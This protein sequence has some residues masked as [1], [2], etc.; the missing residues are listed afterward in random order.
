MTDDYMVYLAS[1]FNHPTEAVRRLRYQEVRSAT[2]HFLDQGLYVYSPIVHNYHID[3]P[4]RDWSFW[5]LYDFAT[6]RRMERLWILALD[7]VESSVGVK[8]ELDLALD[9][10]KIVGVV[11]PKTYEVKEYMPLDTSSLSQYLEDQK[12]WSLQTFGGAPRTRGITEHISKELEEIRSDP[13]DVSEWIDVLILALD[14]YWRAG[15]DTQNLVKRLRYK[16]IINRLRSWPKDVPEDRAVLHSKLCDKP[17]PL[18]YGPC[19]R[20]LGHEGPCALPLDS[21]TL[22][23]LRSEPLPK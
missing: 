2:K 11:N 20:E 15:G 23:D 5:K 10:G 16:Q 18:G 12:E 14:G 8:E 4:H 17:H 3:L 9:L 7:G 13:Q 1:P 19:T 6:I 21:E 22:A